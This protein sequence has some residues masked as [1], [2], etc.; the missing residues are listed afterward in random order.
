VRLGRKAPHVPHRT[1]DLRGQDGTYA[2]Y[3]GEGGARGFYLGFDAPVLRSAIFVSSV[4][5]LSAALQK[6]ASRRRRLA[7][8]PLGRMPRR[9]RAAG[10]AES[11]LWPPR[12]VGGL[13]EERVEAALSALVRSAIRSISASRRAGASSRRRARDLP[14]PAFRCA[15]RTEGGG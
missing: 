10:S 11:V 3:L 6:P 4:L 1:D 7:E 13:A 14:Q 5:T 15:R 8:A 12:R 9:M 2:E